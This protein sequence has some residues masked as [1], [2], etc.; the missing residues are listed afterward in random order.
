MDNFDL[1]GLAEARAADD[2]FDANLAKGGDDF[3]LPPEQRQGHAIMPARS[4]PRKATMLSTMFGNCIATALSVCSPRPRSLAAIA[5]IA[6]S[7]LAKP[8]REEFHR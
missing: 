4:T 3:F 1:I 2:G 6:R 8:G 5:E 7:A